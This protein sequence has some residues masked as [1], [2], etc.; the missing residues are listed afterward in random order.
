MV[1]IKGKDGIVLASDS[2]GTLGKTKLESTKSHKHQSYK[3]KKHHI[4]S[5]HKP[6]HSKDKIEL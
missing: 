6:I 4:E 3:H 5:L 1:S 2:H